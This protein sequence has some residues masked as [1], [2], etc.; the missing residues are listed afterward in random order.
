MEYYKQLGETW[1]D[2]QKKVMSKISEIPHDAESTE[3]YKR[4]WIDM[5]ENDFINLRQNYIKFIGFPKY[6]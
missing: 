1:A 6:R 2:S 4:V 5:F 3:A